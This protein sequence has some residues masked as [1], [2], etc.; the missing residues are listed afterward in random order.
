MKR[1]LAL[2][3]CVAGCDVTV[4]V[5]PPAS[6]AKPTLPKEDARPLMPLL[7]PQPAPFRPKATEPTGEP[8]RVTVVESPP[9][10][11]DHQSRKLWCEF[12]ARCVEIDAAIEKAP[13]R[14]RARLEW[15]R[16]NDLLDKLCADY[17]VTYQELREVL[18]D[19]LRESRADDSAATR[20][21]DRIFNRALNARW[22]LQ[23][24]P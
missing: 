17:A 5:H 12:V 23:D 6:P 14:L 19:S 7:P 11:S 15:D 8:L 10:L 13:K 4:N 21:A 24:G 3:V 22:F 9:I 16:V 2:L 1:V 20:S 18:S